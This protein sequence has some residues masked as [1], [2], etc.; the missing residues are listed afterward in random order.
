MKVFLDT[1]IL[2]AA[3][4]SASGASRHLILIAQDKGIEPVTSHYC[5]TETLCNID[6]IGKK[7]RRDWEDELQRRM[8]IVDDRV[9]VDRPV[10]FT[11]AKDRPVLATALA[12]N[13]LWL[14]TLDREDFEP[15]FAHGVYGMRVATPGTFLMQL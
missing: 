13:C 1:S 5:V 11:A 14:L 8:N 12:S 3:A 4:G 10:V 15:Y 9:T 7:A 6:K 2:L